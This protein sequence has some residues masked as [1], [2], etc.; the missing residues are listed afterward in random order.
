MK[1]TGFYDYTEFR[2]DNGRL[3]LDLLKGGKVT[4]REEREIRQDLEKFAKLAVS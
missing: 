2:A 1:F 4:R 3:Y